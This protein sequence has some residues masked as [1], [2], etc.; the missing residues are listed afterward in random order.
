MHVYRILYKFTVIETCNNPSDLKNDCE[1]INKQRVN[2]RHTHAVKMTCPRLNCSHT[3]DIIRD[4]SLLIP[5]EGGGGSGKDLENAI[6]KYIPHL[7]KA[8]KTYITHTTT[9]TP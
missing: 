8:R 1:D 5:E 2:G 3:F 7:C 4:R 9:P 6:M